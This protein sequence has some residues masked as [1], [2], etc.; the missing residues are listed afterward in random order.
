MWA[1]MHHYLQCWDLCDYLSSSQANH[2]YTKN[3]E[4]KARI[5]SC[6]ICSGS[7]PRNCACTEHLV[8]VRIEPKGHSRSVFGTEKVHMHIAKMRIGHAT[9]LSKYG[10][11]VRICV[12]WLGPGGPAPQ[13]FWKLK[14]SNIA[15]CWYNTEQS[16]I[17]KI[18]STKLFTKLS[19]NFFKFLKYFKFF[20]IFVKFFTTRTIKAKL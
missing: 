6:H 18:L 17:G 14:L 15:F 12:S 8:H 2:T 5:I 11:C 20:L 1:L 16:E 3:W 9:Y 4:P 13:M 7:W 19:Y 10:S